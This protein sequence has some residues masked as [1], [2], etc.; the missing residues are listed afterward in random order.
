MKKTRITCLILA[1][2]L[3]L[4]GFSCFTRVDATQSDAYTIIAN[5]GEDATTEMNISWH[6]DLQNTESYIIYTK[7]DDINWENAIKVN[8]T[9]ERSEQFNGNYSKNANNED[10]YEEAIFLNYSANLVDLDSD[11]EYMYK[12]GQNTLSEVHYFKT[13]GSDEFKFAWISDFHVY[14]RLPARQASAMSMLDTIYN[15]KNGFDFVFCTGDAVAWG[16]SYSFWKDLYEESYFTNYMW[17]SM[18]GNHDNMDRTSTKNS[19]EYFRVANN[20]PQNGYEGQ[21]GVCYYFKYNNALFIILNNEVLGTAI[22]NEATLK[23]QEWVSDVIK[24]NPSQFIIV[25]EH[26][27]W[28]N[29]ITGNATNYGFKRWN[30]FFDEHGVD[31]A[32]GGNNHIY[33]RTKPVYNGVPSTDPTKGTTYIQAPSSDNERGQGMNDTLSYNEELID[34]RWTEGGPTIG[35]SLIEI[36]LEQIKV[37]LLNRNGVVLDEVIIPARRSSTDMSSLNKTKF[38]N[39]LRLIKGS[40]NNAIL[41][42]S[43]DALGYLIR[44][45]IVDENDNVISSSPMKK[46]SQT[47]LMLENVE[48]VK[49]KIYYRDGTV[50]SVL[51]S[52]TE[53]ESKIENVNLDLSESGYYLSWDASEDAAKYVILLNG[54]KV[55][56]ATDKISSCYIDTSN[57]NPNDVITMSV[58]DADNN[59]IYYEEI[60]YSKY[61]D[62]NYDGVVDSK[63]V[64][65]IQDIIIKK[66]EIERELEDY[67]DV[68]KDGIINILDATYLQMVVDN[69]KEEFNMTKYKVS[70]YGYNEALL[71]EEIVVHG[72]SAT[73][74]DLES[75]DN[76][77]FIAWSEDFS[78]ITSNLKVK[79]IYEVIPTKIQISGKDIAQVGMTENYTL[80]FEPVNSIKDIIWSVSDD[81]LASVDSGVV[82][83]KNKG[84]VS[85]FAESKLNSNIKG[86]ITVTIKDV[87]TI[88]SDFIVY[89]DLE[90][91]SIIID[92][93]KYNLSG[94]RYKTIKE[95]LEVAS[96]GNTIYVLPGTYS[97]DLVIDKEVEIKTI[98]SLI[99]PN[100][101]TRKE[102]AI[103]TGKIKIASSNVSI[104]GIKFEYTTKQD[105][106][107][108]TGLIYTSGGTDLENITISYNDIT[109]RTLGSHT[110]IIRLG[111]SVTAKTIKD[112]NIMYNKVNSTGANSIVSNRY[113]DDTQASNEIR[114]KSNLVNIMIKG[115]VVTGSIFQGTNL[116][117]GVNGSIT[118]DSND[119]GTPT[120]KV[121]GV[122]SGSGTITL[123]NH[124]K[125]DVS[126]SSTTVEIIGGLE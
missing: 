126:S 34:F 89:S 4:G 69:V 77:K 68:N 8:G 33:L 24:K 14:S 109:C 53:E 16:G 105:T 99:N 36:N 47:I 63:D 70:F 124:L 73:I 92:N 13:A 2:F 58:Y 17:A 37:T 90:S 55:K 93:M 95:A 118:V 78:N 80:S 62:I 18:N 46:I 42:T 91:N 66:K 81:T 119:F 85:I 122:A 101:D 23:A 32:L 111:N 113:R 19:S 112:V 20:V 45:D 35:G 59:T 31:L 10:F 71:K 48:N 50:A 107:N 41:S 28:F 57:A 43:S 5:P 1:I 82:T 116:E 67:Y 3:L 103:I 51:L 6:T 7:K 98:N 38:E 44:M 87:E 76:Y 125:S 74:S 117:L 9:Y 40:E 21:E 86:S 115:N 120:N 22:S 75:N 110:G 96:N 106:A 15:Y 83:F 54:E 100:T 60:S 52:T 65:L 72:E 27:E 30:T 121:I 108:T 11:T 97:D 88:S 56:E 94:A 123:I 25:S 12:V 84:T 39:S 79:A 26:Y 61:C 49:A 64:S 29:G 102:E 104:T 114:Q